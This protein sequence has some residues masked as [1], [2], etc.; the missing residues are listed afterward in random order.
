MPFTRTDRWRIAMIA[1]GAAMAL[2][3]PMHPDSDSKDSLRNELATMTADDGWVLGHSLI[4]IGT[5]LLAV[6]LWSALR[7]RDLPPAVTKAWRVAAVAISIYVVET[8]MH[9]AAVVDADA[10]ADG[11]PAPV[12]FT[13]IGLA[14]LLY[15]LSGAAFA[16]LNV[17]LFPVLSVPA[18]VFA[19]LGVVGGVL[20]AVSVPLTIVF[21]DAEITPVFA[22]S[23]MLLAAWTLGA[24]VSGLRLLSPAPARPSTPSSRSWRSA[25][26]SSPA[27]LR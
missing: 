6:G 7:A 18:R 4:A 12:A 3:G 16:W 19:V 9:L 27:S 14:L 11:D 24:G 10:L 1:G 2:G 5:A 8:V 15:P 25:A 21:P 20:H 13:H 22:S 17:R 23:G 26:P